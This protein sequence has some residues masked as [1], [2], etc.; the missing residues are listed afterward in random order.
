MRGC[1]PQGRPLLRL[2]CRPGPPRIPALRALLWRPHAACRTVWRAQQRFLARQHKECSLFGTEVSI[3]WGPSRGPRPEHTA[4][5]PATREVSRG[6]GGRCAA[7]R[8]SSPAGG[9][10]RWRLGGSIEGEELRLLSEMMALEVGV[11]V[12]RRVEHLLLGLLG[13]SGRA[14]PAAHWQSALRSVNRYFAY[15]SFGSDP[16]YQGSEAPWGCAEPRLTQGDTAAQT[17]GS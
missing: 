10:G 9:G 2:P 15:P 13:F 16:C 1:P 14:R 5:L 3:E 8:D 12:L 11:R 17:G 4:S 7:V 6:R